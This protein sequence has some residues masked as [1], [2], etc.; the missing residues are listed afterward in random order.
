MTITPSST[1]WTA[2][3]MLMI[4]TFLMIGAASQD[5]ATVDETTALGTCVPAR[6][7]LVGWRWG[8]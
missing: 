8:G 4:I 7:Q 6:N 1:L 3:G 2:I 5:G